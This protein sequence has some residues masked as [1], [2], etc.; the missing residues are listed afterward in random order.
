ML[1]EAGADK[2]LSRRTARAARSAFLGG[3]SPI[4]RVGLERALAD[5]TIPHLGPPAILGTYAAMGDEIDPTSVEMAAM[6]L[7]WRL[8]WPRVTGAAPLS[9]HISDYP[10]LKPGFR[11]ILEPDATAPVAR[12][13]VLLVPLLAADRQGNRLGQGAGHY[14][15]TLAELRSHGPVLAIGLAFDI[16]IVPAVPADRWDQPLDA[17]ATPTAFHPAGTSAKRA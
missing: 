10:S 12:P 7:G 17:I 11:D 13:D 8:A 15:R 16:Q 4:L 2:K 9:F 3:L 6:A 5:I 14:D 1:S